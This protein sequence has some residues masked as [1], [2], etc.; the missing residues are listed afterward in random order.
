V[1]DDNTGSISAEHAAFLKAQAVDVELARQLGVRTLAT[2]ADTQAMGDQWVNWA[3]FPAIAFPW[4]SDEGRVEWQVRPDNPTEDSRGRARKYVFHRGMTPVLWAVRPNDSAK[5]IVII[6]GTKQCLAGASYAPPGDAIYGIA[7]CRMWQLD[8]RPIPDLLAVDGREVVIIL[9]A[10]T[11]TNLEV[12]NA[13][14]ELAEA[15]GME[16]ATK[17]TF[18]RLPGADKSGLDDVLGARPEDRRAGY[19]ERIINTAKPKP[20]DKVPSKNKPKGKDQE[21]GEKGEDGRVMIVVNDD[22]RDVINALTDAL[23]KRWNAIELF[24]HGGVISRRKGDAM[25]PVDKGSFNDLIQETVRTVSK[26]DG[27]NGVTYSFSWPDP[28][29]M[30]ATSSRA[31]R[32]AQLDRISHAPF[33]RPDGTVVTEPGYD[34]TTRTMLIPDPVFAGIAVPESPSPEEIGAAREL[35]LNDWLGDF[36]LDE[37]ADRANLLALIVTPA[38]RGMVP[39]VPMCV[40]DGLQMGV[41]KN[42]LADQL[43]TVYTGRAA[44]PMNWVSDPE[45]MRKQITAAFRGGAEFFVFDEAHT[46]EGAPLAQALTAATWQ[47][48][49]LGVSTMANFP[50]VITWLSLGNQVQ[51]RGDLSRR[52]Y[53]IA[54][55]P[56][57]ANPQDRKAE[58]FR[59]PGQSGLD[60]GSWT[61]KNRR[62]LMTAILTLVRAWFAAGTPRPA[63]GVSFG[64]FEVWER[65][66]GGIVEAA[67]LAGFL[68][69]L[70]V[71]R[72]E[73]DFDTQYW[74][75]HLGWLR[76]EFGEDTFRTADV[77]AKAM[78]DP[79]AYM[80]PPKLDDPAEKGFGKALGEAYSRLRG[81]RYGDFWMERQGSAHGHISVWQVFDQNDDLPPPPGAGPDIP[82][83]DDDPPPW[84]EHA[85]AR[86][87]AP[88]DLD[89]EGHDEVRGT[90]EVECGR[91]IEPGAR[92]PICEHCEP[93]GR[94]VM[95]PVSFDS[96]VSTELPADVVT[97]DL[98]TGDADDLYRT[99]GEEYVR[100]GATAA[101]TYPVQ[102][103]TPIGFSTGYVPRAVAADIQTAATITGHNIMAFDLPALV[104]AGAMTMDEVH[105]LA[106]QGRVFDGLLAA[107][108]LDPPMAR[109]KGV[110]A[111]RKYDLGTLAVTKGLGEKYT[112]LSKPLAAKYGGW[113][114]I[115]IDLTDSDED[116]AADARSFQDYMVQDVELSRRLHA[117]LLEELGGTVPEYLQR[118]HRV[119]A[120][121]AQ[122]RHNGFLVDQELLTERVTEVNERKAQAIGWLHDNAGIPL[123]D[124]KG[125]AYKS[126]LATK[127]GKEALE[128]AFKE[129]GATSFWRTGKSGDFAVSADHMRHLAAEYGHLPQVREIAK[130]VYRIVG[131]RSVYQTALDHLMPDG[132][133]HP[134]IGFEQA[135]GRWSV[136]RPGLTVFGKRGGR[137]VERDVFLPD[138]GEV[139]ISVDLSQ[140]DMRAVAGLS[141]DLAY[142]EMLKTDDPH[143]E[144]AVALFGDGKFRET[145]KAIGHGWNYGE[146][147]TRISMENE[148]DPAVVNR[149][150]RSMYERFGRLVEWRE[151]VRA[152]AASGL[153]LDNGFG[154]MMRA[155]PQRAHTQGP[156]LKGQGAARDLMMTGLLRLPPEVRPMLRAQI[157]DEVVAS[158]PEADAVEIGRVIV[159]AFTFEWRGVPILADVSKAGKTWGACYSKD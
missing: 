21:P 43:L 26:N 99:P 103:Y 105:D 110:D 141:Q 25:H 142:I 145:A 46:V 146:S 77:K 121:A 45:E 136:T 101:E 53:R 96:E 52:V 93:S 84:N 86:G 63:R 71:W 55:R 60:L 135:T 157:H 129:A 35:I 18:G 61:R 6:E 95:P 16:G 156:A 130:N 159:D 88:E 28:N 12:Y 54:L 137:H 1:T 149:F 27:A 116:R 106:T 92:L 68:D 133:V 83:P 17:V 107:R 138:P 31:D 81:R 134:K 127:L 29:T 153:L 94:C 7:G 3:N 114:E 40:I 143:T 85:E 109:D 144:L 122:I 5:R 4:T 62:E 69:N 74:T 67:G 32:F 56:K 91:A 23:L 104:R 79:A 111:T 124:A 73:S 58:S 148:I 147:L 49:I 10:D 113:G 155:D 90:A 48:R 97:F 118:E 120:L 47:D 51:V 87:A 150:D 9:D 75:G 140:V 19:L 14:L 30:A 13:G 100:I 76:R 154:R 112:D 66:V 128:V 39:K 102:E 37:D 108:Y 80:A 64:S 15:L 139:L 42:L 36:P 132:R 8:G 65:I 119:A 11:S 98:E 115:P 126:P 24:N 34:E 72:S 131:A 117:K 82:H 2:R 38:I 44:E 158:V 70:K 22:R 59:H 151:E 33:V 123:T 89:G 41:G 57:Y 50:N 125:K 152:Q 20:A 78:A